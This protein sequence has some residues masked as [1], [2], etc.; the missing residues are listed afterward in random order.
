MPDFLTVDLGALLRNSSDTKTSNMPDTAPVSNETIP[1]TEVG[2]SDE[3]EPN[4]TTDA[5]FMVNIAD[6]EEELKRRINKNKRLP[7]N[8]RKTDYE[9]ETVFFKDYFNYGNPAWDAGCAK[10]LL[11]LGE[12][13][14]KAI[15][16]LGFDCSI[17][18]I[19]G[20]VTNK[21]VITNLIRT[22]LLNTDTFKAIYNAV[23]KKL[24]ADSEF[25]D[26]NDYNIIYCADLYS[27]SATEIVKYL[28]IQKNILSPSAETY[29]KAD[30]D[31]N[32]KVFFNIP[33]ITELDS[34]KRKIAITNL[35]AD[36]ALPAGTDADTTL[37]NINL[38][39]ELYGIRTSN[40][41]ISN[42]QSKSSVATLA[43]KISKN[44]AQAF[45]ALQYLTMR[46][47]SDAKEALSNSVFNS[48]SVEAL[49]TASKDAAKLIEEADLD[50][51]ETKQFV[52]LLISKLK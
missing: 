26:S 6:W 47:S 28:S 16:V 27:K 42:E 38:A 22:K 15:K 43:N 50:N 3:H 41:P 9:L 30:Q 13:L 29:T 44:K 24:V 7:A 52:S 49:V 10:Q 45:V 32:K 2:V 31:K 4:N 40:Q 8:N 36:V 48:I 21:Y 5:A 46:G 11:S 18:P 34:K 39:S 33:A 51:A 12:P 19:L 14:K 25:F 23:A 35:S 1:S 20:F 17:N 37:N